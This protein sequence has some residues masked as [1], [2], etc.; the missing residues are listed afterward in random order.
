MRTQQCA[1]NFK[2]GVVETEGYEELYEAD[3]LGKEMGFV[4][5]SMVVDSSVRPEIRLRSIQSLFSDPVPG[6]FQPNTDR[7]D[8]IWL[9]PGKNVF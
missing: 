5:W 1:T 4:L 3:M 2:V 6:R 7:I 8:R 9:S